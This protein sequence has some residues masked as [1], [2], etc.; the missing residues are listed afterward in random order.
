MNK[1]YFILFVIF[2]DNCLNASALADEYTMP[3]RTKYSAQLINN[4]DG[5]FYLK[6]GV[7]QT[8]VSK[9]KNKLVWLPLVVTSVE[10]SFGFLCTGY[11]STYG[12]CVQPGCI[13]INGSC[14]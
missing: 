11:C 13:C 9:C 1:F 14:Q 4:F 12:G 8:K 10:N 5:F 3:I 7:N 2:F 6:L